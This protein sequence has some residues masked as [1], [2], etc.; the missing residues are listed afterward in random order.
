MDWFY[1]DTLLPHLLYLSDGQY[2]GKQVLSADWVRESLQR[3]S[4]NFRSS[5]GYFRDLGYG[6]QWWSGGAGDN[7]F[8]YAAGHGG[9][10]IVLLDE[11]DMVIVTTADPLKDPDLASGGG[12][13]YESVIIDLVGKFIS[14]LP[15]E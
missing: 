12:W 14:S 2:K 6:Y 5:Y 3:Y 4:E 7:H 9:Q 1:H 15:M 11:L 13:K 10:L 8:N